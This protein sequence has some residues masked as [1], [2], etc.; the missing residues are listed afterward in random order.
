MSRK[1]P[2][3]EIVPPPLSLEELEEKFPA[4]ATE[5]KD[6]K[7]QMIP[8]QTEKPEDLKSVKVSKEKAPA[9]EKPPTKKEEV[10]H[11]EYTLSGYVP[12]A[13]DFIQRCSTVEEAEEIISYLEKKEELDAE[14]AKALR[15]KRKDEGVSSFG[16]AK[17]TGHYERITSRAHKRTI[18]KPKK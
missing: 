6:G 5:M 10:Q 12:K 7:D 3:E 4:L 9:V 14:Q 17:T 2:T 1:K 8:L 16:D 13:E 18:F 11:Q 15:E